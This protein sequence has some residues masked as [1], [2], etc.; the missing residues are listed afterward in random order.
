[1]WA[2]ILSERRSGDDRSVVIAAFRPLDTVSRMSIT[3][4]ALDY[5]TFSPSPTSHPS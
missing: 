5:L 3:I 2:A 1:L 4:E